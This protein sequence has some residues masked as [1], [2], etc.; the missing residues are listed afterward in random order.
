MLDE[1]ESQTM[2]GI[3]QRIGIRIEI[4]LFLFLQ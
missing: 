3:F 1:I 4:Y 2:E